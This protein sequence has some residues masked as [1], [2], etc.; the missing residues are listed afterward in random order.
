[1]LKHKSG[2]ENK[3]AD[4]LSH[5]GYLIQT[6]QVEVLGFDKLKDAYTSCPDLS[7]IYTSLS[8]GNRQFEFVNREGFLFSG[9]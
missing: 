2:V 4:A 6:M 7:L 5:I 3:V 9:V 1:V 8:A